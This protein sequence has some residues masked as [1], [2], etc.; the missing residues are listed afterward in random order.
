MEAPQERTS[1]LL[2]RAFAHPDV[3]R[4]ACRLAERQSADTTPS[5]ESRLA[6][7]AVV[8]RVTDEPEL[9]FIKRA[10]LEG[11]PWSGHIAFPGGRQDVADLSLEV[12]AVRETREEVSLDLHVGRMLGRLDDLAPRS[13]RLPPIIIRPFVAV[14]PR[15]VLFTPNNEV[16]SV[17]WVPI[18]TLRG[19]GAKAEHV[20]VVNG[21]EARFP[22]FRVHEHIVW[23]LTE[24]IVRQLLPLFDP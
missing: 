18:S 8:V 2:E 9:L 23:G 14:V 7:V 1:H 11:D 6:A 21:A 20:M 13:S 17:F 16:A 4:L 10:E 24:R 5:P 22:A 12:T 3:E 19:E 15:D